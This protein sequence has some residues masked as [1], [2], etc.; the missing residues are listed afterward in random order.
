M[1]SAFWLQSSNT[2]MIGNAGKDGS[3]IDIY[4]SSFV[5]KN[6]TKTGSCIHYDGYDTFHKSKDTYLALI[7]SFSVLGGLIIAG[8]ITL[9]IF[10]YK[11]IKD[12]PL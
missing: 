2:G 5:S 8:A 10:H 9:T 11:K 3:E 6:P 7:I 4:E 1:W 12:I